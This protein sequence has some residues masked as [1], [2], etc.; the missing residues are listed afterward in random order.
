M[1]RL[2]ISH[3]DAVELAEV[4]QS[5]LSD[6]RFEIADTDRMAFREMLKRRK[7][8]LEQVLETIR[9]STAA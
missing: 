6:L 1:I 9:T 8:L 2:D 3:E 4:L 5:A 7:A